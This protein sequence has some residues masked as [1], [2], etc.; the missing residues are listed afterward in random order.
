MEERKRKEIIWGEE[1]QWRG[2]RGGRK[3]RRNIKG[4]KVYDEKAS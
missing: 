1:I 2:K 4:Q 3:K